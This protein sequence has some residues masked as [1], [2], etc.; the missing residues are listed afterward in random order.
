MSTL[1]IALLKH[2]NSYI[3][4]ADFDLTSEQTSKVIDYVLLLNKWNKAYNLTAVRDPWQMLIRHV[5]DCLVVLPYLS[6]RNL[7]DVGTGAGLPGILLA[8]TKPN[9]QFTLLDSNHKKVRFVR[10]AS[11][12]L[13][14]TN[15]EVVCERIE[16]WDKKEYYDIVISRAFSDLQLFYQQTWRFI[17]KSGYLLAMKGQLQQEELQ[18]FQHEKVA[19]SII[20]L[21]VPKLDAQRHLIKISKLE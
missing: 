11:I 17:K 3:E 2:L 6:G 14:L 19:N 15:V 18:F 20:S 16:Q 4:H 5:M 9:M 21:D 10:Q 13:R 7:L 12:E 8:I 1:H